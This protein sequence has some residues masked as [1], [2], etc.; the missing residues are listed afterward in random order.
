MH[1]VQ[2]KPKTSFI[3]CDECVGTRRAGIDHI[4][5]CALFGLKRKKRPSAQGWRRKEEEER[6][7]ADILGRG[8][9]VRLDR[10]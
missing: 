10:V 3:V 8:A 9:W 6:S 5:M 4:N 2:K 7:N 1:M